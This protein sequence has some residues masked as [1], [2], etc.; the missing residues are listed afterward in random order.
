[1]TYR[2]IENDPC[3]KDFIR[4]RRL[5]DSTKMMYLIRIN[6]YSQ[7]IG[8]T[9]AELIDE[10]EEEQDHGIKSRKRKIKGYIL[11]YVEE[12][13]KNKSDRTIRGH[14]DTIFSF[15]KAFDVDT[16][17]LRNIV[18]TNKENLSFDELP[19]LK[20]IKQ[21]VKACN[22]RDR[23]IILLHFSSGMGASELRNLTCKDFITSIDE[24]LDL[25]DIDKENL[26]KV[27]V[28]LKDK[29]DLVGTWKIRRYKTDMPYITFN[30]PESTL[31]I[32]DYIFYRYKMNKPIKS[33]DDFLFTT[34]DNVKITSGSHQKLFMRL[35]DRVGFG[36][37]TEK[38]RFFTSHMLR[39]L[40]TTSLYKAGVDKLAIDWMLGH[41]IN[42]VTEA[43]FKTNEEDLKR[44][45]MKVVHYLTLEK[46]KVRRMESN[47]VKDIVR[48][49]DKKEEEIR[50]LRQE[51]EITRKIVE[52]LINDLKMKE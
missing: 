40:F 27:A 34:Q 5:R 12:L 1:M 23:A 18:P 8:K 29:K 49:L 32:V 21:A 47:E 22:I 17:H 25:D 35:N 38:R 24:Y 36:H 39:K 44:N 15:Y 14:L 50:M 3:V 10:A 2:N 41:K 42:P 37:R 51:N 45:Y 30:S 6:Q 28:N 16:P 20:H 11:D 13:K 26:F 52:D 48:D 43:Y 19:D 46:V 33:I 31:A 9:P 4:S 7:F